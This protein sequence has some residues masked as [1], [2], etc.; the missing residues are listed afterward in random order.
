MH[1][2]LIKNFV[3]LSCLLFFTATLL[4]AETW[5]KVASP[6]FTVISNAGEKNARNVAANFERIRATLAILHPSLRVDASAQTIIVVP[7]DVSTFDKLMPSYRKED[8]HVAGLFRAGWEHNYVIIRLDFPD[9]AETEVYH[10]YIHN[11]LH[12][13]FT[14]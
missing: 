14:R 1:G 12:L 7:R 8:D 11:L 5:V 2:S 6:H 10:E 9:F 4:P 3:R 13:N